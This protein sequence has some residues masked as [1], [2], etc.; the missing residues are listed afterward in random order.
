MYLPC[1]SCSC[2]HY[3]DLLTMYLPRAYMHLPCTHHAAVCAWQDFV[4]NN[5]EMRLYVMRGEVTQR[6]P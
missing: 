4:P 2:R 6:T 1:R 3:Y 5:L